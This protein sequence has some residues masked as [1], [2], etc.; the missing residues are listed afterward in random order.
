MGDERSDSEQN[1][2]TSGTRTLRYQDAANCANECCVEGREDFGRKERRGEEAA[3]EE[4][5]VRVALTRRQTHPRSWYWW[6]L[7][8]VNPYM[9]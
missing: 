3:T 2:R 5:R 8:M 9:Y 7:G 6:W 4:D 1:G